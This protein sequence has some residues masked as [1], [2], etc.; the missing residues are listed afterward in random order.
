MMLQPNKLMAKVM[1]CAMSATLF[2]FPTPAVAE[3]IDQPPQYTSSGELLI[4]ISFLS[5]VQDCAYED[6]M[7]TCGEGVFAEYSH[8]FF[9]LSRGMYFFYCQSADHEE[10]TLEGY[11]PRVKE[12]QILLEQQFAEVEPEHAQACTEDGVFNI[13][14]VVERWPEDLSIHW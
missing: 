8:H 11:M 2:F 4:Q 3:E 6:D 14:C 1:A 12:H 5:F 13:S 7:L 10:C 9:I